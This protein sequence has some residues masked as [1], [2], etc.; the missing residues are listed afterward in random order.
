MT[1]FFF[2]FRFFSLDWCFRSIPHLWLEEE[3]TAERHGKYPSGVVE[4]D[5]GHAV[6]YQLWPDTAKF[7]DVLVFGVANRPVQAVL[8][9]EAF[10]EQSCGAFERRGPVDDRRTNRAAARKHEAPRCALHDDGNG[11]RRK[12]LDPSLERLQINRN[13]RGT[14]FV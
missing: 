10:C 8:G 3:V 7:V 12:L 13:Y 1:F 2:L 6:T 4:H 5:A 14:N 11:Q 9:H